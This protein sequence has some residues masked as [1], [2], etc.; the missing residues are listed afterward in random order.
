MTDRGKISEDSSDSPT[1]HAAGLFSLL[2]ARGGYTVGGLKSMKQTPNSSRSTV[3]I[4]CTSTALGLL[5]RY[6]HAQTH[7]SR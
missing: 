1:A 3:S 2:H 7:T 4:I 6:N 5:P